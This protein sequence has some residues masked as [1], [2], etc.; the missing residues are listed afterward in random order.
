MRV[1][2]IHV[3]QET[4]TFNPV[5]TTLEGFRN[6]ALL[7]GSR[8]LERVDPA[9]PIAGCL[10]AIRASGKSVQI[11]PIIRADAQSGGRLTGETLA[12]LT[13]KIVHGLR[14]SGQLDGVIM[15]LHGAAS[16]AGFDDVEGELLAAVRTVIGARTPL[17]LMLDHHANVTTKMMANTD[18]LMAFRTQPH[19]PFETGRDLTAIALR[20]FAGEVKPSMVW[21]KLPMITHQEQYLTASGPMKEWFDHARRLESEGSALTISLF[22]MQPWLDVEEAGWSIVVVTDDDVPSAERM[23]DE[24]ADHAWSMRDRFMKLDNLAVDQAIS[25]A[26][27]ASRGAVL[28][29]DTGD[30]VL[31]GSTG[32][33]TVILRELLASKLKHRALVPVTD[34]VVAR[35]LASAAVGSTVTVNLGGWANSFYSPVTVT[36]TVKSKRSGSV[37]LDGLPQGSVDMGQAVILETEKVTILVTETSGVGGI[38]PGVYRHLG[39]EPSDYKMIVMKTASNFQ[40]MRDITTAFVRVATPGP[41]QSDVHSLPWARIPRPMYPLDVVED[42]RA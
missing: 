41:T 33:S 36:A 15:F 24:L 14:Q 11:V 34:P 20:A 19:D 22:P 6:V 4:D 30:S 1:A 29:S 2:F 18:L 12:T 17:A 9:G 10:Y 40:Y 7:E 3:M 35:N 37:T 8:V 42:W 16:A 32:D 26:D 28:L 31:G 39:I 5:P 27:D 23:A 25:F 38:H 13:D 21:R